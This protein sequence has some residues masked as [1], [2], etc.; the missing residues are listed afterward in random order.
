[1]SGQ[2]TVVGR[3]RDQGRARAALRRLLASGV[4]R[5]AVAVEGRPQTETR[6]A[7]RESS[8]RSFVIGAIAGALVGVLLE[9]TVL[10]IPGPGF[11][12]TGHSAV[13][14][15]VGGALG[16]TIAVALSLLS[17]ARR[18]GQTTGQRAEIVRVIVDAPMQEEEALRILRA[19]GAVETTGSASDGE[20]RFIR[21][22]VEFAPALRAHFDATLGK[23]GEKWSGWEP[24]Y[25]YGWQLA[26]RPDMAGRSWADV[27]REVRTEWERRHPERPWSVP[28]AIAVKRGFNVMTPPAPRESGDQSGPRPES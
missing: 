11:L 22:F 19:V 17:D 8:R 20:T 1:M 24:C 27:E 14:A 13:A 12:D 21:G 18:S 28:V 26:N 7:A 9:A 25:R 2:Q 16:G 23:Q 6:A 3:F 10:A 15:L 5:D 4:S